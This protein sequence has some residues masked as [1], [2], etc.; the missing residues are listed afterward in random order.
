MKKI[1]YQNRDSKLE[2][3]GKIVGF[4]EREYYTFS[5][6]S[7]FSVKWKGK[8][9][10]TSEHAYQA[11]HFLKTA[12]DL[13]NKI[14]KAKSAHEAYKLAK[15]NTDKTPE[16]WH[17]IKTAVMEDIVRHKLKQNPYVMHKLIQTGNRYLVEDSPK[18]D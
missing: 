9:W 7:S 1:K 17:E 10:P 8:V 6:F 11:A 3:S 2:T 13:A 18:D 5:N 14:H 16:N 4:Y 12:P 15:N